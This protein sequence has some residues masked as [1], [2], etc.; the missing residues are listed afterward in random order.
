ME[1]PQPKRCGKD[2]EFP[3]LKEALAAAQDGD[4]IEVHPEC[5][6]EI[7]VIM[8]K[9]VNIRGANCGPSGEPCITIQAATVIVHTGPDPIEI[10]DL[11]I[12]G[13]DGY[14][15]SLLQCDCRLAGTINLN[16]VHIQKGGNGLLVTSYTNVNAENCSFI[17]N[18]SNGICVENGQVNLNACQVSQNEMNGIVA[19][20]VKKGG[21]ESI[22][23][24]TT[25]TVSNNGAAGVASIFGGWVFINNGCTITGH[26]NM[27]PGIYMNGPRSICHIRGTAKVEKND[28]GVLLMQRACCHAGEGTI[29]EGANGPPNGTPARLSAFDGCELVEDDGTEAEKQ[30]KEW[31]RAVVDGKTTGQ[32]SIVD[33]RNR[34]C[35]VTPD[36][37]P[38]GDCL[39]S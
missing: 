31:S 1:D 17:S 7:V 24:M 29:P 11:I 2:Q 8:E 22:V 27:N 23:R 16:N 34:T 3:S 6:P 18:H 12:Q 19:S 25:T 15:E 36:T 21:G 20:V 39:V 32:K 26:E 37:G 5:P 9:D 4:T 13:A 35:G 28:L 14:L 38:G 10:K 33:M 30:E